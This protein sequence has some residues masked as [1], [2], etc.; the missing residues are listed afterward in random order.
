MTHHPQS[1]ARESQFQPDWREADLPGSWRDL[2]ELLGEHGFVG[3]AQAMQLLM[4]EAMKLERCAVLGARCRT[5]LPGDVDRQTA[6]TTSGCRR[7]WA[8]W[9]CVCRK[10][11]MSMDEADGQECPCFTARTA[12]HSI[13]T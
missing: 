6:S 3:M 2:L 1:N 11:A 10:P 12:R 8:H 7:V 13:V 5:R 9:I 4:N